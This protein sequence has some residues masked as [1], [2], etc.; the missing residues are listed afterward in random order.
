MCNTDLIQGRACPRSLEE[1]LDPFWAGKVF[2][3]STDLPSARMVLFA[4]WYSYGREGLE[5]CVK[6]WRQKSAPS[7]ARHGLVKSEFPVALLPGIFSG[8]GPHD[9]LVSI[10]P[11]DGAPVLPSFAA[12]RESE[13]AEDVVDFLIHSAGSRDFTVFLPGSGLCVPN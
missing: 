5:V 9:N 3:G 13:H 11:E 10:W 4:V 6:N 1:L 2:V 12:V 7:A 8:P